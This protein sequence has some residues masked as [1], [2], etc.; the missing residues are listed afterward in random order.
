MQK[1][2]IVRDFPPGKSNPKYAKKVL[3]TMISPVLFFP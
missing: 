3:P 2:F 1:Y